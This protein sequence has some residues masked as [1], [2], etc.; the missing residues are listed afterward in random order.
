MASPFF[1]NAAAYGFGNAETAF[2]EVLKQ[3]PGTAQ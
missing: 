3:S 2:S 1:D